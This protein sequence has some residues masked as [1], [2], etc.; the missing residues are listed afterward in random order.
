MFPVLPN[1]RTFALWTTQGVQPSLETVSF[2]DWLCFLFV[3]VE[4]SAT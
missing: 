4:I 2:I 3:F 1:L